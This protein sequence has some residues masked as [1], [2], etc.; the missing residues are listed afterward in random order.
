MARLVSISKLRHKNE[1][2]RH[3]LP[4]LSTNGVPESLEGTIFGF[5]Y[6]NFEELTHL[7]DTKNIGVI[8]WSPKEHTARG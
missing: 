4:G 6:N 2:N 8:K 3:L 7:L 1:L 5:A